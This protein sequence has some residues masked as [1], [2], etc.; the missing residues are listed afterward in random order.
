MLV[1]CTRM[2]NTLSSEKWSEIG[3]ILEEVLKYFANRKE[4]RDREDEPRVTQ[5]VK[6]KQRKYI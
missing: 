1:L 5:R 3:Y 6:C 4:D 2:T